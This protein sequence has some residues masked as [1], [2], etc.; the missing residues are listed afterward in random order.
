MRSAPPLVPQAV[1][2]ADKPYRHLLSDGCVLSRVA[3]AGCVAPRRRTTGG[4]GGGEALP[5]CSAARAA[6]G[7]T[8]VHL[9]GYGPLRSVLRCG[10]GHPAQLLWVGWWRASAPCREV[11]TAHSLL[12]V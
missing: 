7:L 4:G 8:A 2:A 5:A 3:V 6:Q 1:A 10:A 9:G 12:A 11:H